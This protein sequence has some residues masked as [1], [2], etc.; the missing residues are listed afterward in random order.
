M[1]RKN[2]LLPVVINIALLLIGIGILYFASLFWMGSKEEYEELVNNSYWSFFTNRLFFNA[3]IGLALIAFI[4]V[5]NWLI[6]KA[7]K[8]MVSI[9]RVLAID[10]LMFVICSIVFIAF[11]LF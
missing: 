9:K 7:T 8:S 2:N 1:K 11:Q 10:F 5:V 4:G 3:L 6:L